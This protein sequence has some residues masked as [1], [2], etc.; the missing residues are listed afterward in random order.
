MLSENV[1]ENETKY[2]AKLTHELNIMQINSFTDIYTKSVIQN[3]DVCCKGNANL[4][5]T[6]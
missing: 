6:N 5:S 4:K 1:N 3:S 2:K